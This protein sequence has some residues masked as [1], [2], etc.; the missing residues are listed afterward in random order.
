MNND[1]KIEKLLTLMCKQSDI[2]ACVEKSFEKDGNEYMVKYYAGR[3]GEIDIII[4]LLT[5]DEFF[6]EYVNIVLK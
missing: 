2:M 3:K 5:D 6:D 1:K 4:R